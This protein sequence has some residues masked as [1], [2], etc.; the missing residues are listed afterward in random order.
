[1]KLSLMTITMVKD[2]MKK[3]HDADLLCRIVKESGLD[4]VDMIQMELPYYGKELLM[5]AWKKYGIHCGCYIAAASFYAAPDTVEEEL[6]QALG[7]AKEFGAPYLMVIPGTM[8]EADRKGCERLG[9][10]GVLEQAVSCFRKA[11]ELSEGYG[12]QVVFENTPHAYKPLSSAEDC[13]YVLS[14][15]PG[16]KFVFDTANFRVADPSNDELESYELLKEWIVRFHLK[17]VSIGDYEDGEP[18]VGG[19]AIKGVFPGCGMIP[20]GKIIKKAIQDGFDGTYVIEYQAPYDTHSVGHCDVI[21]AYAGML[22]MMGEGGPQRCP[23]APFPGIDKPVSKIFFGTAI[24]PMML[25]ANAAYLL[26]YAYA[27][28]INAFDCARGYGNAEAVLGE[29]VQKRKNRENIIL[30]TKCGNVDATG[31]VL[32]NREVIERELA[33]SLKNLQTDYI[34]I[35][36]L[37]RDDPKTPVS[38]LIE[39]LN[40]AKQDGRIRVFGVSNWTHERI[41]E[42]N[43]YAAAKGLCG[44]TVSSPNYGLARQAADPWG[45]GC[46]TIAGPEYAD[47][48]TWYEKEQMPVIAYSSLGRGFFSGKFKSYDYEGAG[49]VLDGVAQRAYLSEDNME[50]LKKLEEIAGKMGVTVPQ[51]ALEY[52]LGSPMKVFAIVSMTKASRIVENVQAACGEMAQE[53][54]KLLEQIS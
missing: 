21:R 12:I 46:V 2:C 31:N 41:L 47:A 48:R 52:V 16:L 51:A 37:H 53:D 34:D 20:I 8:E 24:L 43:A 7:Q 32:V 29:W 54:W 5:S 9:R 50:R 49:K 14:R 40:Q 25:N 19:G 42:A 27:C 4:E 30:L 28:G 26:D 1:M 45:G 22:Q 33:E 38:E 17:E 35:Y 15:V 3:Y 44:F 36:L 10:E 18:C 11:V 13:R 23:R 39:T 6:R